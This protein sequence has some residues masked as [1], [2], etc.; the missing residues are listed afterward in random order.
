MAF[1]DIMSMRKN[2][3]EEDAYKAAIADYNLNHDDVWAKR[4]LSWCIYDGLKSN[5]T[6]NISRASSSFPS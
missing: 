1:K 4:A 3:N 5:A 2:G 6:Y